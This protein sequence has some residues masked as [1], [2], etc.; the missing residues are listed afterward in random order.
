MDIATGNKVDDSIVEEFKGTANME[1]MLDASLVQKGVFPPINLQRSFTKNSDL[2]LNDQEKE[3]LN[4]IRQ[5]LGSAGSEQAILQL[6][7]MMDKTSTNRDLL[8]KMKDW[9]ALMNMG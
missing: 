6:V 2:I 9:F 3:G 8:L 7:S 4:L 1:L 5:L